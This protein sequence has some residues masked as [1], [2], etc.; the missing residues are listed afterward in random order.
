MIRTHRLLGTA[1][2][3]LLAM[4]SHS[5]A[6]AADDSDTCSRWAQFTGTDFDNREPTDLGCTN[7]RNLEHMVEDPNDLD[8]GRKLGPADAARESLAVRTYEEGKV[9]FAPSEG[10][11]SGLVLTPMS[12]SQGSQ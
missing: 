6:T 4:A 9:K 12:P 1:A 8:R 7:R 3:L 2:F 10:G 5:P 11:A